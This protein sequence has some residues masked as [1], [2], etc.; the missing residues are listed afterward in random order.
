MHFKKA[1]ISQG[2]RSVVTI[3]TLTAVEHVDRS[4]HSEVR[5]HAGTA[6]GCFPGEDALWNGAACDPVSGELSQVAQ[7][8]LTHSSKGIC[9]QGK[10]V[11]QTF[12][13][14]DLYPQVRTIRVCFKLHG[15]AR[16]SAS[17]RAFFA[18]WRPA[19]AATVCCC[20]WLAGAIF[21]TGIKVF[22]GRRLYDPLKSP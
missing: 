2:Q 12:Q 19:K 13:G 8:Y 22:Y 15:F 3:R 9:E 6:R 17:S 4:T 20:P 5:V 18:L 21:Y 16:S 11:L 1:N 10:N 7:C 14:T